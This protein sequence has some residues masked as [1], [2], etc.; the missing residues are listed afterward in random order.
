MDE[1]LLNV[2]E[3]SDMLNISKSSIYNYVKTQ[4]IPSIKIKGRLLFSRTDLTTWVNSKK[5]Q[6]KE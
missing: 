1:K 4:E 3:V 6:A 5:K 2:I